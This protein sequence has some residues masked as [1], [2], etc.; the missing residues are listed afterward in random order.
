VH[1]VPESLV[2]SRAGGLSLL[3]DPAEHATIQ[4]M[5][6]CGSYYGAA[7]LKAGSAACPKLGVLDVGRPTE[8]PAGGDKNP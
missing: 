5:V 8:R 7:S 1:P 3:E 6:S 4:H 2:S